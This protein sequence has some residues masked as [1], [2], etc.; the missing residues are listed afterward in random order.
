MSADPVGERIHGAAGLEGY[1]GG[2]IEQYLLP[3]LYPGAL[4]RRI[5]IALGAGVFL[6]NGFLYAWVWRRR[7][8]RRPS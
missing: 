1:E 6:L 4:T 7:P 8:G 5:Q 3:V 2:V